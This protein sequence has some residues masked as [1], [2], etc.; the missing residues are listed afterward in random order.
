[1]APSDPTDYS[2][3]AERDFVRPF[4]V[5]GGRT[6]SAVSGLRLVTLVQTTNKMRT[7]LRFEAAR[8]AELC[9]QAISIAEIS[10]RLAIPAGTVKVVVG[11]LVE[12]GHLMTHRTIEGGDQG[13]PEDIQLISRLIAGVKRL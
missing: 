6:R 4:L 10:A 8:V 2:A 13:A 12:S 3:D 9:D 5:T 1:M 7:G 11:D